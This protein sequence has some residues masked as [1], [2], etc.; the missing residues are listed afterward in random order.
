MTERIGRLRRPLPVVEPAVSRLRGRK[1]EPVAEAK[2]PISP[3][4]RLRSRPAKA[5]EESTEALDYRMGK[6]RFVV[7]WGRRL[8]WKL[9]IFLVLSYMYYHLGRSIVKDEDYDRL[10]R[11][12]LA[13]Y[14]TFTHQHKHLVTKSMLK[15]GTGFNIRAKDY[16]QM[17]I[18][19]AYHALD[20]FFEV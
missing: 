14:D 1:V 17:V 13:G 11:E 20:S 10:A 15:A 8:S 7:D 18:G 6:T 3:G 5:A 19:A 9:S 12:L 4:V 2:P 16:P